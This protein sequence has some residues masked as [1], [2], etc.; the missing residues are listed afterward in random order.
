[1][2]KNKKTKLNIF[3][4]ISLGEERN[5]FIENLAM[6][7]NS[8]VGIPESLDIIGGGI[9][10]KR[11]K[12]IIG[13]AKKEVEQGI[14]LWRALE[15]T[16]LF[17]ASSTTL[18]KIGEKSGQLGANLRA[19]ATQQQK[20]RVAISKIQNAMTYP[21]LVLSVTLIVAIGIFWFVLPKLIPVFT[22]LN[23]KLPLITQIFI[24]FSA[25]LVN[26]GLI[27][28]PILLTFVFIL[29]YFVFYNPKT[30]F[31]GQIFLFSI[32]G[33]KKLIKEVEISRFGYILGN[34]LS[35]GVS[36][37][38]SLLVLCD[39]T[40]LEVYK[41][42]YQSLKKNVEEGNS[43]QKSFLFYPN[44][45]RLIP[46]TMIQ[47]I[48]VGEQSGNLSIVLKNIGESFEN[49]SESTIKNLTVALEPVMLILVW[50]GVMA[51]ALSVIL[52]IYSLIGGMNNQISP[53]VPAAQ[54]IQKAL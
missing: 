3:S 42:M 31:I 18:I 37:N 36:L 21:V 11:V 28:V 20:D 40:S 24:A 27:F 25:F 12:S 17:S 38:D 19:I 2:K 45:T 52:P 22:E 43:L 23:V 14:P 9:R 4:K 41:K 7:V 47:M 15:D 53:G 48:S 16:G 49:K 35:A 54:V 46:N 8:G 10:S 33:I 39:S 13:E 29:G 44:T 1:M 32:P 51:V 34:L 26:Y 50:F 6:L 5:Y 30:K